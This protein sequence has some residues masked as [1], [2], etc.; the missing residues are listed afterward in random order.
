MIKIIFPHVH[1]AG[2]NDS[3]NSQPAGCE[4][5]EAFLW[6]CAPNVG[7]DAHIGPRNIRKSLDR[8]Q[9]DVGIAPY[10]KLRPRIAGYAVFYRT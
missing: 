10:N 9:G 8:R 5:C 1:A 3:N 4:L 7:A 6:Y 2:E